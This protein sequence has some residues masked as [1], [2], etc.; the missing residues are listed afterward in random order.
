MASDEELKTT[1]F[2][3][4][5]STPAAARPSAPAMWLM[6]PIGRADAE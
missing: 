3:F 1:A 5:M 2:I 6:P 4:V